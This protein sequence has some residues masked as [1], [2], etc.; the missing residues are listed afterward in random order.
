M[1]ATDTSTRPLSDQAREFLADLYDS[2][3]TGDASPWA[4]R[5]TMAHEPIV[6]GTDP[7]E[8]WD[9]RD[10]LVATVRAQAA[11]IAASGTRFEGGAAHIESSGD[12]AWVADE[13]TMVLPDGR[14]IPMRLTGVFVRE[15]GELRF[16][17]G[18]L[19]V[20][21]PNED[22]LDLALPV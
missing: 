10:H 8:F 2:F 6:I 12:V 17:Q 16:A 21:H 20:G 11:D 1:T 22:M 15:D 3:A 13:P 14:T 9:D 18:H 5:L 19:S 4:D 7:A